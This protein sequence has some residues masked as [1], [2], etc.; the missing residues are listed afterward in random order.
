MLVMSVPHTPCFIFTQRFWLFYLPFK[1]PQHKGSHA[2][3]S[4]YQMSLFV[5]LWGNSSWH[6][7]GNIRGRTE[8]GNQPTH[9][10]KLR[11]Q[12]DKIYGDTQWERNSPSKFKRLQMCV[13]PCATAR[14]WARKLSRMPPCPSSEPCLVL[15][16]LPCVLPW[17][18]N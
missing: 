10:P 4:R 18:S 9:C 12:R 1:F 3:W 16:T 11:I 15:R 5:C 14:I 7:E 8:G 13:W 17:K 6:T 2:F